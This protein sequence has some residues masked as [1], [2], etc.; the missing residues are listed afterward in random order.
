[1]DMQKSEF[2]QAVERN[3]AWFRQSGVM[4][5]SDGSWGVAERLSVAQGEAL[6][7]MMRNFPACYEVEQGV[8]MEQRRADC[9]FEAALMF[10][11]A[12]EHETGK[13]LLDYLYFRS[14]LLNR[15]DKSFMKG[16]WRWSHIQWKPTIWIDDNAWCLFIQLVLAKLF[17]EL[18]VR[19]G[20]K[21]WGLALADVLCE[22][23]VRSFRS[24]S[25]TE[26]GMWAD[27]QKQWMGR[28]NKPHWGALATMALSRAWQDKPC[29]AYRDA[30]RLF[31]DY[32]LEA[33]DTYTISDVAYAVFGSA[34]A[35]K[36]FG[37][38]ADL[39]LLKACG[40]R[41]LAKTD[42]VN[43]NL[44]AEHHE[45]PVGA[46]LVD[47]IYTVNWSLLAYQ[48]L[49][50]VTGDNRYLDAVEKQTRLLCRIQDDTD[51][52]FFRGCWRGMYDMN[53]KTWG[54][55]DCFEGGA[56]S[57]YSGWTNAPISI[58][59]LLGMEGKSMLDF[60]L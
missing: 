13:N 14:G 48:M 18:D 54:G 20:L 8:V 24:P 19:Y 36:V 57:I 39:A 31:N 59:L 6:A 40:E 9:N 15:Y 52:A 60:F 50:A 34:G 32:F 7:S 33:I 11:L 22:G 3:L 4:S 38:E 35:Y 23:L 51:D 27:P 49:W 47:T 46:H 56:G 2:R 37:N 5:P 12:G 58:G 53:A 17:P 10:L 45:A 21:E 55:G 1:M 43:G 30:V 28:T 25:P 16:C 29:D 26:A 42:A 41:L 44:P